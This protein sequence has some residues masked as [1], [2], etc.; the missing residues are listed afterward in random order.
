M[1]DHLVYGA[2]GWANTTHAPAA[3]SPG[4]ARYT[5]NA[6]TVTDQPY[7]TTEVRNTIPAGLAVV[8][9]DGTGGFGWTVTAAVDVLVTLYFEATIVRTFQAGSGARDSDGR[10]GVGLNTVG[11]SLD[12][13]AGAGRQYLYFPAADTPIVSNQPWSTELTPSVT[14]SIVLSA[15]DF[16]TVSFDYSFT[17]TLIGATSNDFTLNLSVQPA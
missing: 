8:K 16:L 13:S 1:G 10:V 9:N 3:A 5:G 17:G 6:G 12:Q 15:T 11:S 4:S 7:F 2:G 14:T